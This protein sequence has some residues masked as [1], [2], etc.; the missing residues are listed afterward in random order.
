MRSWKRAPQIGTEV[1]KI[2]RKYFFSLANVAMAVISSLYWSGY[3][4]D[5]LCDTGE[6]VKSS[7][8]NYSGN[9]TG[10]IRYS[11]D[12]F[13]TKKND[14]LVDITVSP[15]DPVYKFCLQDLMKKKEYS[16][17]F[18]FIPAQQDNR[19]GEWMTPEQEQVSTVFGWTA[20]VVIC[21]VFI[22]LAL[23]AYKAIEGSF[24]GDYK[25]RRRGTWK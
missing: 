15:E 24:V 1:S 17:S 16:V 19:E 7:Y 21:L 13:G 3:P 12:A 23:S 2:S 20:V 18:P 11:D 10:T 6:D 14:T 9:F 4:Y 5:N 8:P 25:V 22:R